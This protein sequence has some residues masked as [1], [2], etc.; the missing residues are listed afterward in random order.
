MLNRRR[1][2]IGYVTFMIG[3]RVAR[4]VVRKKAAA[5]LPRGR[6]GRT[7]L[8]GGAAVAAACAGGGKLWCKCRRG[9]GDDP[10]S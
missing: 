9:R 4:R 8:V 10:Q 3:R 6:R 7:A 2:L 5:V 1:A